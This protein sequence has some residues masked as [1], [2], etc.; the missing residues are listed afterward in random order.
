MDNIDAFIYINLDKRNDRRQ[1]I[2]GE[3]K[4]LQIPEEKTHRIPGVECGFGALGCTLAHINALKFA[5]ENGYKNFIVF[6]DDFTFIVDRETL[7]K[8]IKAFFDLN[9]DYRVA[10]LGYHLQKSESFNDILG[11]AREAQTA[12]SYLVSSN[13]L[14]ELIE[15]LEFGARNLAITGQHWLY[16]NDQVWKKLQNEKWYYFMTRIGIQ[17][18]GFSDCAGAF[19]EYNA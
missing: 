1:E 16:I 2:L 9:L 10:M 5:K 11:Y 4:K 13:Y 6:E 17:R 19:R 15:C 7:E 18:P 3:F 12:S 14:D 8:N